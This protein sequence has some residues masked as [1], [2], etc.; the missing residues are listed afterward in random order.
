MK[1]VIANMVVSYYKELEHYDKYIYLACIHELSIIRKDQYGIE[2]E[3]SVTISKA[4][5]ALKEEKNNVHLSKSEITFKK[6][7][8][9]MEKIVYE[10]LICIS[11]G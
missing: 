1:L 7:I 4:I 11:A 5:E 10:F 2:I 3:A 8:V 9:H 6:I